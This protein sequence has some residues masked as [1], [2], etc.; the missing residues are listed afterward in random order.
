MKHAHIW[1]NSLFLISLFIY[2][3]IY[4]TLDL[5][6]KFNYIYN[7]RF[8]NPSVILDGFFSPE[9]IIMHNLHL[10]SYILKK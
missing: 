8:L 10:C 1:G 6:N 9:L 7:Q 5:S 2:L 4:F 3:C